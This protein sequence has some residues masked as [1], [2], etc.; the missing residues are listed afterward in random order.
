MYRH[1]LVAF[2]GSQGSQRALKAGLELARTFGGDLC[3]LTVEERLPHYAAT[4]G[5]MDE[6]KEL[7]DQYFAELR[8][9]A[10]EEARQHGVD[11]RTEVRM[12]QA[13]QVVT[14]FADQGRFDLVVVGQS[15]HSNVWGRFLGSTADKITRHAPCSVLVVR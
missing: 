9:R 5:E 15:G 13:A 14:R 6:E 11:I 8:T 12:G 7:R 3:A 1:I 4:V 2:D 10:V